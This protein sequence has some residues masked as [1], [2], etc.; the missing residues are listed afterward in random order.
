MLNE[1]ALETPLASFQ[2]QVQI[3]FIP[4]IYVNYQHTLITL[5]KTDVANWDPWHS[6]TEQYGIGAYVFSS[7]ENETDIMLNEQALETSL[8]SV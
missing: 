2:N 8:A 1:Q 3:A 5:H 6:A 7:S 4:P